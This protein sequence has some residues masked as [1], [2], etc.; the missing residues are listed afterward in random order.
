M[1]SES[2]SSIELYGQNKAVRIADEC[3]LMNVHSYILSIEFCQFNLFC[4]YLAF[5]PLFS[6]IV[7]KTYLCMY[8][9]LEG[10]I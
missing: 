5:L 4:I 8:R 1:N 3:M 9:S 2:L 6:A 7:L 10:C